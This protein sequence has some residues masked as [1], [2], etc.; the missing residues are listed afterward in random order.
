MDYLTHVLAAIRF[1]EKNLD[2]DIKTADVA[3]EVA[4]S[5][6]H[7][8]RIF[9]AITGDTVAGYIRRRRL[10]KAAFE[11]VET[12]KK[13]LDIAL[14]YR[15]ETPESF[16]R[17]FRRMY[18]ISPGKYRKQ[19]PC[20]VY[21][22]QTRIDEKFLRHIKGG[23]T[24]EPRILQMDMFKIVG[25]KYY[26]ENK[27][28]EIGRLWDLFN[29]RVSEIKNQQGSNVRYGICYP[30]GDSA[31]KGEFEYIA[32]IEVSDLNEIPEGMVGRTIQTQTY[33]VFTH[34]GSLEK[35]AET[36]KYIYGT[37]HP[38]SGYELLKTPDFEYYDERF[39]PDT[40][41]DSEFDIYIPIKQDDK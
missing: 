8:H 6:Y 27:N 4:F 9:L 33:A 18:G 11:L 20:T 34:K 5:T 24:M 25:M 32:L 28:N 23:I 12:D 40:E 2:E 16:S 13:I 19:K 35:I 14:D 10:T 22:H 30:I 26:G 31:E 3:Q 1:I 15:F 38:K 7:F 41:E 39:D 37:W 29:P 21:L 17:A 36:Y